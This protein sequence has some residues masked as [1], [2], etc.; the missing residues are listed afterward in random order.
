[1]YK[2]CLF[3]CRGNFFDF[4]MLSCTILVFK[5]KE[6][7]LLT[8]ETSS[9][10]FFERVFVHHTSVQELFVIIWRVGKGKNHRLADFVRD[11][12]TKSL[13]ICRSNSKW[14]NIIKW[15]IFIQNSANRFSLI[16]LFFFFN[17]FIYCSIL[18]TLFYVCYSFV[19]IF[20]YLLYVFDILL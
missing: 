7:P 12:L 13:L 16:Y 8:K 19:H 17:L 10:P 1:M 15:S 11:V 18:F 3:F 5:K 14:V 20:I 2:I 4:L 9:V 6:S